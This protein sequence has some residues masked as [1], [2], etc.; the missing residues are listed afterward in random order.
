MPK[1]SFVPGSHGFRFL[2]EFQDKALGTVPMYGACG[3]MSY[4]ALDY[5]MSGRAIP[6]DARTPSNSSVLGRY[7]WDRHWDSTVRSWHAAKHAELSA[8]LDDQALARRTTHAEWG[9]LC[10]AIDRGT[11]VVL[12]LIGWGPVP[13]R[14]HQV[15]AYGYD[16]SPQMIYVYD[17]RVGP[18]EMCLVNDGS[19]TYWWPSG[20]GPSSSY[21]S[22]D[23]WRGWFVQS[24]YWPRTPVSLRFAPPGS[25]RNRNSV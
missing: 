16:D 24:G 10:A 12:G 9:R 1:T 19:S 8:C 11:T 14:N 22:L 21:S 6:P 23:R 15:V 13:S 17:N 2:N 18:E 5:F 4:A 20:V 7:I 3:G 25:N